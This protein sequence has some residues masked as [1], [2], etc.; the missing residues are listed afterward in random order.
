ML[1]YWEEQEKPVENLKKRLSDAQGECEVES[2]AALMRART[3]PIAPPSWGPPSR[4]CD[5]QNKLTAELFPILDRQ[6]SFLSQKPT[7]L[8]EVKN[9]EAELAADHRLPPEGDQ[10]VEFKFISISEEERKPVEKKV[11]CR[12][13]MSVKILYPELKDLGTAAIS[14]SVQPNLA[15]PGEYTVRVNLL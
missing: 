1:G 11:M 7:L 8:Q 2:N 4:S 6:K 12:G 15:T 3:R 5:Q 14:Y 13:Q 10:L 9:L